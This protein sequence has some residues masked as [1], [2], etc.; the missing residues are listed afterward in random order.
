MILGFGL[1]FLLPADDSGKRMGPVLWYNNDMKT[2]RNIMRRRESHHSPAVKL[3]KSGFKRFQKRWFQDDDALYRSLRKGQNPHALL[4]ACSDSRVDPALLLDCRPGDLFVVRNVAN[5]VPPYTHD[6][7]FHGVSA[8]IE[9]AV[10]HL[11]VKEIIVLGHAC[12]GGIRALVDEAEGH[13]VHGEPDEFIG[14]WVAVARKAL[15]HVKAEMPQ[16]D[17]EAKAQACE[18]WNVRLALESLLTFPWI[19]SRAEA[20]QLALH[21]WYFDLRRGELWEYDPKREKFQPFLRS[22]A[23]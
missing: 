23:V 11:E 15:E 10:K 21:G 9:Y 8:A 14:P 3:L 13:G 19:K 5:L 12:C 18:L 2:H 22:P 16:A 6:D 4:I 7:G 17:R 1:T 20:G